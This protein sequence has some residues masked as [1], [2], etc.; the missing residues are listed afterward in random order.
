[1]DLDALFSQWF[2]SEAKEEKI[3][4]DEGKAGEE[5]LE[6][7]TRT[8]S[9]TTTASERAAWEPKY[10]QDMK[11]VPPIPARPPATLPLPPT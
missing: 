7:F 3:D 1:M 5:Q 10:D 6:G 11:M 8:L 9:N 2:P 4:E